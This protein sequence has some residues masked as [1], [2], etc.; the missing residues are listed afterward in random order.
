MPTI[1]TDIDFDLDQVDDYYLIDEL[2]SRGYAVYGKC[3]KPNITR[4]FVE[5]LCS[6]YQTMSPEFFEKEL[7]KFFREHLDVNIY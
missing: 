5:E 2:E 7:K 3:H 4:Y 6:T 1:T